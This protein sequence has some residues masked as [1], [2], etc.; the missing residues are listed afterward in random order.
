[1]FPLKLLV[2]KISPPGGDHLTLWVTIKITA[3]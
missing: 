3:F 2:R 1:M